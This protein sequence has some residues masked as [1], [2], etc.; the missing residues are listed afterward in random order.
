MR[1]LVIVCALLMGVVSADHYTYHNWSHFEGSVRVYVNVELDSEP[2]ESDMQ[3]LKT[4]AERVLRSVGIEV[5][6]GIVSLNVAVVARTIRNKRDNTV[7]IAAYVST[8]L[9]STAQCR[10]GDHHD[11]RN[12]IHRHSVVLPDT[13]SYAILQA[14]ESDMASYIKEVVT[15]HVEKVANE[16]LKN[17]KYWEK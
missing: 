13:G 3:A 11:N 1:V 10:A 16:I 9:T 4:E 15:T 12:L 6:T 5:G 2:V 14:P 8:R 7:G 17:K